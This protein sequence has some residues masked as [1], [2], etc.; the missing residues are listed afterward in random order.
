MES[1]EKKQKTG[2]ARL[3][4]RF[5]EIKRNIRISPELEEA[6]RQRKPEAKPK[7]NGEDQGDRKKIARPNRD[8]DLDL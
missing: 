6:T 1:N 3:R 4:E 7:E 2:I 8:K 5:W